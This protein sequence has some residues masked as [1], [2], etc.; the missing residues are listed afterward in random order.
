MPQA[1]FTL[2]TLHGGV[3]AA[4]PRGAHLRVPGAVGQPGGERAEPGAAEPGGV[5]E[6][7][8][9]VHDGRAHGQGGGPGDGGRRRAGR[10]G[11][12]GDRDA[13]AVA[14]ARQRLDARRRGRRRGGGAGRP[15]GR[16]CGASATARGAGRPRS[17]RTF[18]NLSPAMRGTFRNPA[19]GTPRSV[20]PADGEGLGQDVADLHDRLARRNFRVV[21]VLPDEVDFVDLASARRYIYT[22]VG[23]GRWETCEVWP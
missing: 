18:G 19:P 3:G 21:V 5:R 22:H 11:V 17:R 8:A 13:D 16:A 14:R 1:T 20:P 9:R 6:R 15:S 12:V 7:P 10:G 23:G 4:T 2:S